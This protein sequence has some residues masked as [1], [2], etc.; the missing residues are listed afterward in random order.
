MPA[1]RL[2]RLTLHGHVQSMQGSR[3]HGSRVRGWG[4]HPD[5]AALRLALLRLHHVLAHERVRRL[6][7]GLL[8]L[9]HEGRR[10]LVPARPSS[11]ARPTFHAITMHGYS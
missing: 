1:V 4:A 3:V 7:L 5:V 9:L 10:R 11:H 2:R 8:L 6:L